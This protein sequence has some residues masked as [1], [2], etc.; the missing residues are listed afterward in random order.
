MALE[1]KYKRINP[2]T[3]KIF[4]RGDKRPQG[5]KQDERVFISYL[6]KI[7]TRGENKGTYQEDW[8]VKEGLENKREKSK[9]YSKEN[10][11]DINKS[12]RERAEKLRQSPQTSKKRINPKTNVPFKRGDDREED[13]LIFKG[14]LS[15]YEIDSEGFRKEY[16]VKPEQ[17]NGIRRKNPQTGKQ[18]ERG[19]R[20]EDGYRFW[21]YKNSRNVKKNGFIGESWLN[22]EAY[23]NNINK[24]TIQRKNRKEKRLNYP[25]RLNPKTNQPFQQG[26]IENGR[27]FV[28]YSGDDDT[29]TM[30]ELER[31]VDS[32]YELFKIR[33]LNMLRR[34]TKRSNT[35]KAEINI[36]VPYL[37][38]IFPKDNKCPILG[39]DLIWGVGKMTPNSPSL[40]KIVPEKGYVKGN[41]AIISQK[42]NTMKQDSTQEDLS[43]IIDYI[44]KGT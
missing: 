20:R 41:V 37:E 3:N 2:D 11:E 38:T 4:V 25:K 44:K 1:D 7:R 24:K 10:R 33:L 28:Q 19:D 35:N 34:S 21:A 32:D 15:E 36:D 13:D 16:W 27:I 22:P 40:D 29:K 8:Q 39:I 30:Y 23:E 12:R 18:Y 43:K 26:D 42:A 6:G 9:K 5:E 14:Y 17:L 31:W